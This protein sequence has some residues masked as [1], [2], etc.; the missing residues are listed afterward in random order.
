MI[1]LREGELMVCAV[2]S[3]PWAGPEVVGDSE[4]LPVFMGCGPHCTSSAN[5]GRGKDW[6]AYHC[7]C[8]KCHGGEDRSAAVLTVH[9]S[10]IVRARSAMVTRM[11]G[12]C[13]PQC[14]G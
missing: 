2:A 9:R 7:Y 4:P 14:H 11:G 3:V 5:T 8:P 10:T 1:R 12:A 13:G 6:E